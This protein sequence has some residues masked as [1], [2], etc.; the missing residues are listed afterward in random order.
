MIALSP[1]VVVAAS[2]N[3]DPNA[4]SKPAMPARKLRQSRAALQKRL[5]RT[6]ARALDTCDA[7]HSL[8]HEANDVCADVWA[9]IFE[10]SSAIEAIDDEL[11]LLKD[12]TQ[13][14]KRL[15]D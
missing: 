8:H 13:A 5:R 15:E 7:N 9:D 4:R 12:A 1:P 10:H 3:A 11:S 6:Y 2:A 14:F